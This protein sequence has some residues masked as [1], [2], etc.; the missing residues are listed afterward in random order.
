MKK[1]LLLLVLLVTLSYSQENN[2]IKG[3]ILE[4][5]TG[6]PVP[7]ANVFLS[8]TTI[9]SATD[10][11]GYFIIRSIPSGSYQLIASAIGYHSEIKNVTA[12]PATA[13]NVELSLKT[14]VYETDEVS[15]TA[16]RPLKWDEHYKEFSKLFL[17][18]S[19]YTEYCKIE[20]KEVLSFSEYGNV[21]TAS[22]DLPLI[23]IN[24]A[25]GYKIECEIMYFSFDRKNGH[26]KYHILPKFSE[27]QTAS[28]AEYRSRRKEVYR[29]SI[30]HFLR[31]LIENNF[32]KAGYKVYNR[33]KVDLHENDY[34][35]KNMMTDVSTVLKK[36]SDED[37]YELGFSNYLKV[38]DEGRISW[39]K[40]EY[41]TVYL[42]ALGFSNVFTP[43]EVRGYWATEGISTLLP[44]NFY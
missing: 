22:A 2:F 24:Q 33:T 37:S 40:L 34:Y 31:S 18:S 6:R 12:G 44:I 21:L 17:G 1:I 32:N 28:T 27:I 23:I 16:V 10:T 36:G 8:G 20:N 15:I 11:S 25:L 9:G 43:F 19:D 3:R 14:K 13:A 30:Q 4:A 42:N 39:I 5:E 29:K 41:N 7:H 35:S 26:L 38:I